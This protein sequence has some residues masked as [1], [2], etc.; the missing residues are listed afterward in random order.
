MV[1]CV[2]VIGASCIAGDVS[3]MGCLVEISEWILTRAKVEVFRLNHSTLPGR[4]ARNRERL[5]CAS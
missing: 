3:S 2:A 5:L 1:D 4:V